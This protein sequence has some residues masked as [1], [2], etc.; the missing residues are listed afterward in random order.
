MIWIQD[1]NDALK[2]RKKPYPLSHQTRILKKVE[3][4]LEKEFEKNQNIEEILIFGS[5]LNGTFGIY[6]KPTRNGR[7]GS[8][9]DV[10]IIVNNNFETNWTLLG[11]YPGSNKYLLGSIEDKHWIQ[12]LTYNPNKY[13]YKDALNM[14]MPITKERRKKA[15]V[16]FRRR[17]GGRGN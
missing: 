17:K 7:L 12:V 15:K 14:G 11:K 8:D 1:T 5:I 16:L 3:I 4:L 6:E 2:P 10:L 13:D 9:I